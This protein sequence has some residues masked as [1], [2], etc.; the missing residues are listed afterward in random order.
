MRLFT[1]VK[2]KSLFFPCYQGISH[3]ETRTAYDLAPTITFARQHL[4]F[5]PA[6]NR[7]WGNTGFKNQV[8]SLPFSC[9]CFWQHAVEEATIIPLQPL[10]PVLPRRR[11]HRPHR[12]RRQLRPQLQN[13]PLVCRLWATSS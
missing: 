11:P 5:L 9:C 1:R 7:R 3:C 4:S 6:S 13:H 2:K 8:C 12:R 10:L